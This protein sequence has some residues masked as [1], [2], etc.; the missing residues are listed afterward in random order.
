MANIRTNKSHKVWRY[1]WQTFYAENGLIHVIDD[2]TGDWKSVSC[3]EFL[4]RAKGFNDVAR[5]RKLR[6]LE[7]S[8]MIR[9]VE[10]MLRCV[11]EASDQGDPFAPG[12][13]RDRSAGS[14]PLQ[15]VLPAMPTALPG[16]AVYDRQLN[17]VSPRSRKLL[18]PTGV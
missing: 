3:R 8:E 10:D 7:R 16:A 13:M 18:T 15:V 17:C 2:Q 5:Q 1:R 12:V 14:R 4:L 6:P 9:M 11:R